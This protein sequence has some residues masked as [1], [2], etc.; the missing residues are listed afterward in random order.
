MEIIGLLFVAILLVVYSYVAWGFVSYTLYNW[1]VLTAIP[2]LPT[3]SIVQ[4]IG[5][6]LFLNCIIRTPT[7]HLKDDYVDTD[8]T[9]ISVI[10][11]PWVVLLISSI[12]K[13]F[14]L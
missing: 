2:E 9:A 5:F 8:K 6:H 12:V 10:L 7:Q 13:L 14:F 1:F 4:F 3:F 11:T